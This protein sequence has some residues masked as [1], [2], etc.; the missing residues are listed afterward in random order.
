[1]PLNTCYVVRCA[2]PESALALCAWLNSTYIRA[3]ARATADPATGGFA[4]FNARAVGT[5]PLPPGALEDPRLV[6]LARRGAAG[7]AVQD[8]L[9]AL[10]GDSLALGP[11]ERRLLAEVVGVGAP[12]R[13]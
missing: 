13:R 11:A 4:R 9:D 1:V 6:V 7:E 8:E 5:V 3:V 2:S 10:V 12:R